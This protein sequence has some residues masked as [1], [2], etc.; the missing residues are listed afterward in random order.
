[1]SRNSQE[2]ESSA[3]ETS[4]ALITGSTSGIGRATAI[5]LAQDGYS[6]VVT[7]RD[8][9]RAA[10]TRDLIESAGGHAVD[11]PADLSDPAQVRN[12]IKRIFDAIDGPL[13]VVVNNA[14][15]G[16]FALTEDATENMFD[17]S[18][19]THVKAPYFLV[20]AF[21]PPMAERGR[22][23]IINIGSLSTAMGSAG[24]S[25]FQASKAALSM[26]TK[27]WTAEYGPRGVQI[28]SVD[29]GFVIT[30][31]T[32]A[33]GDAYDGF[34]SSLPAGRGARPEEIAEVIRFLASPQATYLQGA[35]ISVDGG[36]N[37]VVAM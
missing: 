6:I 26:L 16:G 5:R 4:W 35:S 21:A 31:A 11:L 27:S 20:A 8:P 14:G 37:A 25:I 29:P 3:T 2:H 34:L 19:N 24:T 15:G 30:P 18:F 36:K 13:D 23:K 32:E 7:G 12:L 9:H 10:E 28:N 17:A 33:Y 22:G 1:M